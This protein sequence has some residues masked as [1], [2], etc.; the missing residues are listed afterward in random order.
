MLK[1]T[2]RELQTKAKN[3]QQEM[4]GLSQ[5]FMTFKDS[6]NTTTK[7]LAN[8]SSA[9]RE[10]KDMFAKIENRM[11]NEDKDLYPLAEKVM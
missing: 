2:D 11:A 3:Y 9:D 5:A 10:I 1:S 6:Y 4:G 7:V 8:I